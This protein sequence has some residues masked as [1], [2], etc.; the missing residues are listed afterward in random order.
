MEDIAQ[1]VLG[2]K[3]GRFKKSNIDP[4]WL[5][6]ELLAAR[7][8][9]NRDLRRAS[10]PREEKVDRL[11]ELLQTVMGNG[12]PDFLQTFVSIFLKEGHTEWLGK[13]LKG[14]ASSKTSCCV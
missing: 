11:G 3:I 5:A 13:E 7:I 6:E 10:N 9:G 1:G 12:A 2:R 8:I 4:A 14:T